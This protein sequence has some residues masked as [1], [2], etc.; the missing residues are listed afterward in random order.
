MKHFATY[1]SSLR[2][3]AT[4]LGFFSSHFLEMNVSN[5]TIMLKDQTAGAKHRICPK[6]NPALVLKACQF[7]A[8]PTSCISK[9]LPI[10][11][12]TAKRIPQNSFAVFHFPDQDHRRADY[13]LS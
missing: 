3:K 6:D 13:L 9:N 5:L 11:H 2:G 8:T 12:F 1:M 4:A 7:A 10:L